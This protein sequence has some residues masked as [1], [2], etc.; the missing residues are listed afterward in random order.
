MQAD[1]LALVFV[2]GRLL[3]LLNKRVGDDWSSGQHCWRVVSTVARSH[4]VHELRLH[5]K[6]EPL[7][8]RSGA[9]DAHPPAF[10]CG[11]HPWRVAAHSHTEAF[12]QPTILAAVPCVLRHLT[13]LVAS[14]LVAQLLADAP[15]E[16][17]LATLARDRPVVSS[18][19]KSRLHSR[20]GL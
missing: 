7:C 9:G 11:G 19:T 20:F 6:A 8:G 18:C 15:L 12:L 17:S 1:S 14:A 4:R 3:R 10:L 13:L 2:F 16:E 5:V